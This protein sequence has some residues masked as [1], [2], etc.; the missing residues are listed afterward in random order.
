MAFTGKS[1]MID[2]YRFTIHRIG[3]LLFRPDVGD[4]IPHPLKRISKRALATGISGAGIVHFGVVCGILLYGRVNFE[5]TEEIQLRPYPLHL[6]EIID[7]NTLITSERGGGR[8]GRLEPPED[9]GDDI[10]SKGVPVPVVV[11]I[12]EP[13]D[14]SLIAEEHEIAPQDEMETAVAVSPDTQSESGEETGMGGSGINGSTE[15]E[16]GNSGSGG[17]GGGKDGTWRYDT[18]PI[19][20]RI[21]MS[22]SR[23]EI[24]RKFRHV[25]DSI[26]RFQLLI[27]ETGEVVDASMIESTGYDEIDM[28][29]LAKIYA[30][31]YHPAT[32]AGRAVKAWIVV[33]YGY[34]VFT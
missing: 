15:G 12:P 16:S 9:P 8:L 20:R 23:K 18:P 21:N 6:I 22:I 25:K 3:R 26:V 30:A 7:P 4:M 29:L 1:I 34:R 17:L 2:M 31:R 24:P 33:G 19:P 13:V 10:M 5:P 28:L 32:V 14:D 27:D 11:G